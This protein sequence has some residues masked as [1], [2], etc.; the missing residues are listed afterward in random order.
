MGM[1]VRLAG[2]WSYIHTSSN[3]TRP[4]VGGGWRDTTFKRNTTFKWH[5]AS[6]WWN[7]ASMLKPPTGLSGRTHL[8][9]WWHPVGCVRA[10]RFLS[11][12]RPVWEMTVIPRWRGLEGVRSAPEAIRV[13]WPALGRWGWG[14]GRDWW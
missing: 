4:P 12:E 13:S 1:L 9:P 14:W 11:T 6:S 7:M 2:L 5:A 10:A 8:R 3:A